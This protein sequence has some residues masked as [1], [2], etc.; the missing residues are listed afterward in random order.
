MTYLTLNRQRRLRSGLGGL[1]G[2]A[3]D[4]YIACR[5]RYPVRSLPAGEEFTQKDPCFNQLMAFRAEGSAQ[6]AVPVM[7][8]VVQPAAPAASGKSQYEIYA[9]EAAG[10]GRPQQ[11]SS[12]SVYDQVARLREEQRLNAIRSDMNIERPDKIMPIQVPG[13]L[14]NKQQSDALMELAWR[15]KQ[16]QDAAESARSL[17]TAL[18]AGAVAVLGLGALYLI[19]R[20]KK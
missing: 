15:N 10:S 13:G 19:F 20:S 8:P 17:K 4:E 3:T 2:A 5:N 1:S 6:G 12:A 14:T 7:R 16:D 18:S 11:R 9:E